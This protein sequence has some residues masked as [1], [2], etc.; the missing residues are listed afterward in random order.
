LT[1][2][3]KVNKTAAILIAAETP[4]RNPTGWRDYSPFPVMHDIQISNNIVT[5]T[6]SYGVMVYSSKRVLIT[7]N[8]F[9]SNS[10][11]TRTTGTIFVVS[12]ESI[13]ANNNSWGGYF[14]PQFKVAISPTALAKDVCLTT[15]ESSDLPEPPP[16]IVAPTE[17]PVE[18]DATFA[19][20]M[21]AYRPQMAQPGKVMPVTD[22]GNI[23]PVQPVV[24]NKDS[25][26]F[27]FRLSFAVLSVALLI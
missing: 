13:I 24:I 12:G 23:A 14:R 6:P 17:V 3:N 9:E 10:W 27:I 8:V 5:D 18:D 2:V 1:N 20:G 4:P 19:D 22:M 16:I 25:S 7:D 15:D 26:A 21:L 11:S